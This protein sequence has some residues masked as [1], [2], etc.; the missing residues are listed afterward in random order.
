MDTKDN[1]FLKRIQATFRI[2]AE[3][4]IKSFSDGLIELEKTKTTES[5]SGMIETLFREV[6]SLKGAARSVG[7]KEIESV[8]QPLESLFSSLK[9]NEITMN[10]GLFDLFHKIGE[11]LSRLV[12]SE[13]SQQTPV[14]RQT[15]REMIQQLRQLTPEPIT[16]GT[17]DVSKLQSEVKSVEAAPVE[18]KSLEVKGESPTNVAKAIE[19]AMDELPVSKPA[20]AEMVRISI[21]KLDP[22]LQQAEEFLQTKIAFNQQTSEL[23]QILRD[24]E[25]WKTETMKWRGRRST[26]SVIQWNEWQD[27]NEVRLNN[28]ETHLVKVTRFMEKERFSL[29]RQVT[30]H[31]DAM[32]QVLMLPVSSLVEAFPGMVREIS[33]EQNKEIEFIILGSDLEIDKRILEELK[34]PLNH[35]IRNSI[36]HGIG[37][38][39]ERELQ[40]KLPRGKITMAFVAKENG[41]VEISVSDDGKGIDKEKV[42]KAALK[43]E[44]I[45]PD[46]AEKLNEDEI[47]SLIYQSGVSTSAIITDLSGRGLGLPIVSE[48]VD[49]LNGKLTVE[50][51][52]NFGTTFRIL[53]PMS[54]A[55]FRGILVSLR[56]FEF[57]LPTM[58]VER[59]MRVTPEELK[60]VENHETI[61]IG[62]DV[63]SVV[64]LADVLGLPERRKETS[65]SSSAESQSSGN[66]RIVV[67][68]SGENRMAF[69]VDEVLDEHQVLV[70]GL[71][72]LLKRVRNISGVTILGSGKIVPVLHISDL[73]KSAVRTAGRKKGTQDEGKASTKSRKILVAEDSITSRTLLKNILETA[74]YH[75]VTAVDGFDA[76]TRAKSEE[77]DLIVTDVD[78]PRLNGFE[79]TIKIK[80]DKKLS[81]MPVVLVTSLESREDRERGIEAGADAYIIKSKFDQGNLLEVIKK[82]I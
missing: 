61:C 60:T 54:L 33:R 63:I 1:E 76:F 67:L 17:Q 35:L 70:K 9:R 77:F 46:A 6:H 78:M 14:E 49:K 52:K 56:E 16:N 29:D 38:P 50:T 62:E 4:H 25:E 34:D 10:P 47:F 37:T 28:L 39:R 40:H 73:M 82:L 21:S 3:E 26:A 48:K 2:E 81:E 59:V 65:R 51:E 20:F 13:G 64:S 24:V 57:I 80:N 36:D 12:N 42:L 19:P 44:A 74:G 5:Q 55:A 58:N 23:I 72:K 22:L 41:L 69:K 27:K 7:K 15:L 71:G 79:L 18:V 68:I 8:C 30:D 45:S 43:T 11:N 53:I 31:L 75:V 32:K 66:I